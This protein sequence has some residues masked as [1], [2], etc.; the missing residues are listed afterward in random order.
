MKI[1]DSDTNSKASTVMTSPKYPY[2]QAMVKFFATTNRSI[3][4]RFE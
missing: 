1:P 4:D 3:E 2:S